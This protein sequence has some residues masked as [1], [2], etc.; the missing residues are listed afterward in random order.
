[1]EHTKTYSFIILC[2]NISTADEQESKILQHLLNSSSI[3]YFKMLSNWI[4][5]G[6]LND[7]YEEF[8]IYDNTENVKNE[9]T[10][11][12]WAN[13]FKLRE[14]N[15]LDIFR[16]VTS[17]IGHVKNTLPEKVL[18]TGKYLNVIRACNQCLIDDNL[19]NGTVDI[20]EGILSVHS[21]I[22]SA[23]TASSSMLLSLL[24]NE[25]E[26][27]HKMRSIIKRYFLLH[28]QGPDFFTQFLDAAESELLQEVDE[29]STDRIKSLLTMAGHSHIL[30]DSN[31]Q[32]VD[33][34]REDF[35]YFD[36]AP[37]SLIDHLDAL[38]SIS[39]GLQL[40]DVTKS[41]IKEIDD[42]ILN[43]SRHAA[44]LTGI[45]AFTL[46]FRANS[47]PLSLMISRRAITN[48]QL[49]FRHLF[50]CKHVE[51]RLFSTWL[52]H[53]MVKELNLR[54]LLGRTYCL[55]QRMLH[56][57]QNFVYYMM[58]EVI[59]P[60][61]VEFENNLLASKNIDEAMYVHEE[62]QH[63]V[64][65]ECLLTNQGLLKVLAKLMSTCLLFSEQMKRFFDSTDVDKDFGESATNER[66]KRFN[67]ERN[68]TYKIEEQKIAKATVERRNRLDD[69]TM[70]LK[71]ELN[72][73]S[74]TLMITKFHQVFD[75]LLGDFMEELEQDANA[76]YHSHLSNLA[77]R[78]DYNQY[79]TSR[80]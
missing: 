51:R 10:S 60:R 53:Q 15:V 11:I 41:T 40:N 56:F 8:M 52:D 27:I 7:I 45:E 61:W 75:S 3:P 32:Q 71:H 42:R 25:H 18:T 38:H 47:L 35:L 70:R 59:E 46:D 37:L 17:T 24:F 5:S 49:I 54:G 23:F 72:K 44:P 4:Y 19:A 63:T 2:C 9:D 68:L 62:F 78:L 34:F 73:P 14:E 80:Q 74:Y 29:I 48:Y 22:Q 6:N 16:S 1:M 55:R 31:G 20:S 12:W 28:H 33:L 26:L 57:L 76:N 69:L 30:L 67:I 43:A 13:Q 65:K 36:F 21:K 39:G 64:M 77:V 66:L 50:F 79:Y 58:F